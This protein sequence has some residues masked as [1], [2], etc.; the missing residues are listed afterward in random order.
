MKLEKSVVYLVKVEDAVV[1]VQQW[2]SVHCVLNY[3]GNEEDL[4]D[5][6]LEFR[7]SLVR[8]FI[9]SEG[10]G[11]INNKEVINQWRHIAVWT[12]NAV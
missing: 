6:M 11:L 2:V 3:F 9:G 1:A 10:V 8:K 12:G 4:S 7:T 5:I